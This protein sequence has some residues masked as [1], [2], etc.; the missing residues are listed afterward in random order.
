[1]RLSVSP[2]K[3]ISAIFRQAAA[4]CQ[5]PNLRRVGKSYVGNGLVGLTVWAV[6][7]ASFAARAAR[8]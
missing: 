5:S 4:P 3:A 6:R 2:G 8:F 1:M 7:R